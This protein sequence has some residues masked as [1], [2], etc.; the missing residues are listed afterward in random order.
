[1]ESFAALMFCFA[2][3]LVGAMLGFSTSVHDIGVKEIQSAQSL[4]AND[5]GLYML[6]SASKGSQA[7]CKNGN[8]FEVKL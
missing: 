7:L 4:C 1:M 6:K 2:L 3:I 8:K 5:E